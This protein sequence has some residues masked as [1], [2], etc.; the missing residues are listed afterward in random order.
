LAIF[1]ALAEEGSPATVTQRTYI[2]SV[3]EFSQTPD[4]KMV[5]LDSNNPHKL[6]NIFADPKY[7]ENTVSQLAEVTREAAKRAKDQNLANKS[8]AFY[9]I[10]DERAK[11]V[12]DVEL[13]ARAVENANAIRANK[14]L[15]GK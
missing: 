10:I 12:P 5:L 2:R 1:L 3:L 7:T 6:W 8:E 4:G 14:C 11:S 13:R 15:V 9:D